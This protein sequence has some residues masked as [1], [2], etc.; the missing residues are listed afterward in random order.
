M[1]LNNKSKVFVYNFVLTNKLENRKLNIFS[2]IILLF[3][4]V[5]GTHFACR[6]TITMKSF[7]IEKLRNRHS[8]A[9]NF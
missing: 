7:I 5:I 1:L 2:S 9:Y 3:I 6:P 8:V 4:R